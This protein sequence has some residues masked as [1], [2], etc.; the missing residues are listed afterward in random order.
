[1]TQNV[2]F[3]LQLFRE[4]KRF[5]DEKI[6]PARGQNLEIANIMFK[7]TKTS[8]AVYSLVLANWVKI[9]EGVCQLSTLKGEN[10]FCPLDQQRPPEEWKARRSRVPL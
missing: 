5:C 1:M 9:N 10:T 8:F 6:F 3:C 2:P 4:S 7:F